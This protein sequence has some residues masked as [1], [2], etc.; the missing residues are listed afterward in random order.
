MLN[1]EHIYRRQELKNVNL[2]NT[3]SYFVTTSYKITT[4]EVAKDDPEVKRE[5]GHIANGMYRD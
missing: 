3:L 4:G 5:R 2:K 1:E